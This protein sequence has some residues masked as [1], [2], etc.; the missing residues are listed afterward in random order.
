MLTAKKTIGIIVDSAVINVI[1]DILLI[2]I[3]Y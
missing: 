2:T 1:H 3:F